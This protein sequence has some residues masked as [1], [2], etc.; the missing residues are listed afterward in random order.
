MTNLGRRGCRPESGRLGE[1]L[2]D[3]DSVLLRVD[4]DLSE[5][6]GDW[7]GFGEGFGDVAKLGKFWPQWQGPG[8]GAKGSLRG[9]LR[10]GS[11][12]DVVYV[13]SLL[14]ALSRDLRLL[15]SD[16]VA[17]TG[18]RAE[19]AALPNG[20]STFRG[21]G[22]T[23]WVADR[24]PVSAGGGQWRNSSGAGSVKLRL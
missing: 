8:S 11:L 14:C 23:S 7:E 22:R 2:D 15:I 16:G 6:L 5:L 18:C 17:S 9:S 19:S 12:R 20:F 4:V 13:F 3:P 10:G 1:L 21:G 24:F